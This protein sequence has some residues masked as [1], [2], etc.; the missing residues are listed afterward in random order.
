MFVAALPLVLLVLVYVYLARGTTSYRRRHGN[1]RY[2]TILGRDRN[3]GRGRRTATNAFE[4]GAQEIY[5]DGVYTDDSYGRD[6]YD[7]SYGT[8]TYEDDGTYEDA[9]Y[10]RRPLSE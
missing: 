2:R 3:S 5:G 9:P 4:R 1:E 10:E 7:D 6:S 8:D